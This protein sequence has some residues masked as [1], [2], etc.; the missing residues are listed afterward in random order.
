MATA[1]GIIASAYR[2]VGALG[3]GRNLTAED[4]GSGLEALNMLLATTSINNLLQ[5]YR[6]TEIIAIPSQ[7][8]SYTIGTD[9]DLDTARP[10]EIGSAYIRVSNIDYELKSMTMEQYERIGDK[11]N[12]G[13]PRYYHYE[14]NYPLGV[15]YFDLRPD[16]SMSINITSYKELTQLTLDTEIILPGEYQ[17]YLKYALAIDIA[18]EYGKEPKPSVYRNEVD[19][20]MAIEERNNANRIPALIVESVL[21]TGKAYNINSE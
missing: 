14:T 1:R 2:M 12:T 3:R 7:K 18:P 4:A 16:T 11:T 5:P 17:R 8:S 10:L 19:S 15:I 20:R 9:G 13:E 21:T 6:V